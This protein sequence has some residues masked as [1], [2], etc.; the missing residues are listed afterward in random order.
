MPP[1]THRDLLEGCSWRLIESIAWWCQAGLLSVVCP[2]SWYAVKFNFACLRASPCKPWV[3]NVLCWDCVGEIRRVE[4]AQLYFITGASTE[5][6]LDCDGCQCASSVQVKVVIHSSCV[7]LNIPDFWT[8]GLKSD[9]Q[10][11]PFLFDLYVIWPRICQLCRL[12]YCVASTACYEVARI[13]IFSVA[14]LV[15]S[16]DPQ[17]SLS[18]WIALALNKDDVEEW[19][20]GQLILC[21]EALLQQQTGSRALVTHLV[22]FSRQP[23]SASEMWKKRNKIVCFF[24]NHYQ[25]LLTSPGDSGCC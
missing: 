7:T 15:Q 8:T 9:F 20:V 21:V 3:S 18:V 17:P 24:D 11:C 12:G 10:L 5:T 19:S 13:K 6:K 22:V 14:W 1:V 2:K 25:I 16:N 4:V 23:S